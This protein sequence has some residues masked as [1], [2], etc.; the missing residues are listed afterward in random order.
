MDPILLFIIRWLIY[1]DQWSTT[2]GIAIVQVLPC[3]I[4]VVL[5]LAFIRA[6]ILESS[7]EDNPMTIGGYPS[8]GIT[9]SATRREN[10]KG[11]LGCITLVVVVLVVALASGWIPR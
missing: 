1:V 2:R 6:R 5:V 4:P 9:F 7:R 10:L 11:A 8:R 3:A